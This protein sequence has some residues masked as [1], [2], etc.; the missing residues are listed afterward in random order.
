MDV[1]PDVANYTND[2]GRMWPVNGKYDDLQRQLYGFMVEL[3]KAL[4]KCLRPGVLPAHVS[5][6]ARELVRPLVSRMKFKNP[7][8]ERG[9]MKALESDGHLTHLVG[10][11]VHDVGAYK[12]EPFKPGCVFALDPQMWI[13]EEKIYIRV[14]DTVVITETGV[15]S[16]TSAAPLELDDVE[17]HMRGTSGMLQLFPPLNGR[18]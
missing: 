16:L 14:E 13:P 15:E 6:E 2:I 9:V 10:M 11:A 8:H 3:H 17:S 12:T 5:R 4:L 7:N 1:A 18:S